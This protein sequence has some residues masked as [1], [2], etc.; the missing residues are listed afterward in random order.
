MLYTLNANFITNT[1]RETAYRIKEKKA[2]A[3]MMIKQN[4]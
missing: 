3:Q 2:W 1:S 4:I